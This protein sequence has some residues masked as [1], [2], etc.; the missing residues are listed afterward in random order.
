MVLNRQAVVHMLRGRLLL[1]LNWETEDEGKNLLSLLRFILTHFVVVLL[2]VGLY[3][4][5]VNGGTFML[6]LNSVLCHKTW[7]KQL[8][9]VMFRSSVKETLSPVNYM[10]FVYSW[11]FSSLVELCK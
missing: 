4:K 10:S 1:T 3:L 9:Y 11:C 6:F 2:A 8:Q 7:Y 5:P